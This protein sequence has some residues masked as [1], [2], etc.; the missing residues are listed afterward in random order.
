[1]ATSLGQR[2]DGVV[3]SLRAELAER[4]GLYGG[5]VAEWSQLPSGQ[6]LKSLVVQVVFL[7]RLTSAIQV[8]AFRQSA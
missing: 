6:V 8:I 4:Y 3:N 1:M 5:P 7:G 2:C